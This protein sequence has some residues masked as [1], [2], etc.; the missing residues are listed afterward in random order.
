M[1]H[2]LASRKRV[3]FRRLCSVLG[4]SEE[5]G[6]ETFEIDPPCL[7]RSH[8]WRHSR[9]KVPCPSLALPVISVV[10]TVYPLGCWRVLCTGGGGS[11]RNK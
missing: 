3:D 2:L 8:F 4:S 11:K 6:K 7:S 1:K 10:W 9:S 5:P